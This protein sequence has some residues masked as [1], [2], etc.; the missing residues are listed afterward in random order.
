MGEIAC[1]RNLAKVLLDRLLC[2]CQLILLKGNFIYLIENA[3]LI[4]PL[5]YPTV[6]F[7]K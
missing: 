6:L 1:L 7:L 4:F 3:C 2:K 5:I